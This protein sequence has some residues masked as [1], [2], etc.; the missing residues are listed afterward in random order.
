MGFA[1]PAQA[2]PLAPAP[3]ASV[4]TTAP[5][6]APT[7]YRDES[8]TVPLD[9]IGTVHAA[10]RDPRLAFET[11][12]TVLTAGADPNERHTIGTSSTRPAIQP[13]HVVSSAPVVSASWS[14]PADTAVPVAPTHPVT[15]RDCWTA[16]YPPLL[17]GL[18]ILGIVGTVEPFI[19]AGILMFSPFLFV[20][21]VRVRVAQLR[22]VNIVI[23]VV[24]LIGWIASLVL[25]SSMYNIDLHLPWWTLVGC[26][27]LAIT[28]LVLQWL[29]LRSGEHLHRP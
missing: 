12:S 6:H 25:D 26:W 19:S 14:P 8:P 10:S 20:P 13:F 16:A 18:T 4:Q 2:V 23:L 3:S 9:S 28:D 27:S 5:D 15:V 7:D 21:R 29:G 1:H 17:V 11:I 24:L 22:T